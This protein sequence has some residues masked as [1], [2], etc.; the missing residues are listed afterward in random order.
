MLLAMPMVCCHR[1]WP[2]RGGIG[3]SVCAVLEM[4]CVA[5][6][7]VGIVGAVCAVGVG[8][9]VGVGGV[10]VG[11]GDVVVGGNRH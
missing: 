9:G 4:C 1:W 11:I 2:R 7:V 6:V 3:V 10:G 5:A 8:L